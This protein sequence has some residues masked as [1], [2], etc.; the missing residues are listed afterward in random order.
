[1]LSQ[2]LEA[3]LHQFTGYRIGIGHKQFPVGNLLLFY[4]KFTEKPMFWL[5]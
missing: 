5:L 2:I 3:A 1:M 4:V